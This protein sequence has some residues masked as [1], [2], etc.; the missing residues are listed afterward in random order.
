MKSLILVRHGKA[1][2][3]KI[4]QH[5]FDRKLIDRG[6]EDVNELAKELK[7]N[8]FNPDLII[9]SSAKRAFQT[10]KILARILDIDEKSI[11]KKEVIYESN[12]S[13]LLN[14]INT[15]EDQYERVI[16]TGHNPTFEYMIEYL[17]NHEIAGGLSTSG[18]AHISFD[19]DTWAMVTEG[20]GVLKKL[21][22]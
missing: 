21:Y 5:D 18:A 3:I 1:E 2:Q 19:I 17:S 12:I 14:V 6:I 16:I 11:V 9:S 8:K 4:D 20:I 10:A 7:E 22:N 13:V 15:I